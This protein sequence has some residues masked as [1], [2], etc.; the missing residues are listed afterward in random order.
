M[1][2]PKRK[3]FSHSILSAIMHSQSFRGYHSA[4]LLRSPQVSLTV[5]AFLGAPRRGQSS[6]CWGRTCW[7]LAPGPHLILWPFLVSWSIPP[8]SPVWARPSRELEHQ[9]EREPRVLLGGKAPRLSQDS[10]A[11]AWLSHQSGYS[12]GQHDWNLAG[13]SRNVAETSTQ[14]TKHHTWR[15]GEFRFLHWQAQRS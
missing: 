12:T 4:S 10:F 5:A 2:C 6:T 8:M 13:A 11:A 1:Q 14:E 15:V 7:G 3:N 9:S